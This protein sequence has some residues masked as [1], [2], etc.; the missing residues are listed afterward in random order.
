MKSS[1]LKYPYLLSDLAGVFSDETNLCYLS[2]KR[3]KMA[4]KPVS[5]LTLNWENVDLDKIKSFCRNEQS[6]NNLLIGFLSYDLGFYIHKIKPK[7]KTVFPLVKIYSFDNW[8]EKKEDKLVINWHDKNFFELIKKT[9]NKSRI[10][11]K[12]LKLRSPFEPSWDIERYKIAF[13]KTKDYIRT[14]D[15]YQLNLAYPLTAVCDSSAEDIFGHII[16]TN[17]VPMSG[18]FQ[19]SDFDIISFSPETFISIEKKYIETFPIKG[20]RAKVEGLSETTTIN[21]LLSDRKEQA[22]LN[23]IS[24]LLRND[25]GIVCKPGSVRIKSKKNTTSLNRIIHTYSHIIGELKPE[26]SSIDA[27]LGVFPGGSIS[28][29]PKKRAIEIID[30]LEEYS[31]EAYTGSLFSLDPQDRLEASILIRTLIK[32]GRKISLPVGGGIVFDSKYKSEYQETIDKSLPIINSF[33]PQV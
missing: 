23:M 30:E 10:V 11:P 26:I 2:G 32:K 33:L 18:L 12:A 13:D 17:N 4:F 19:A 31:R 14:G 16:R 29:C 15:I 28:G 24:D 6:K 7:N 25:L 20:T 1:T 8:I 27:L 3:P 5:S 22:E 21:R 9:A